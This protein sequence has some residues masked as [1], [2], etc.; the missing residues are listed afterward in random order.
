MFH[1][2]GRDAASWAYGP[3]TAATRRVD[4]SQTDAEGSVSAKGWWEVALPAKGTRPRIT[5]EVL[6][7]QAFDAYRAA[8][9]AIGNPMFGD[10]EI[11]R[12]R[13]QVSDIGL[14]SGSE[15]AL[16]VEE[17]AGAPPSEQADDCCE[18]T[19]EV[20]RW[21]TPYEQAVIAMLI[22]SVTA[23]FHGVK[24]RVGRPSELEPDAVIEFT[25]SVDCADSDGSP[26][27]NLGCN[28]MLRNPDLLR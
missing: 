23:W 11:R 15:G 10:V 13:E 19:V 25:L 12:V 28:E 8:A 21:Q 27:F 2:D 20:D 18:M 7:E 5:T 3:T 24:G 26:V 9:P 17:V 1:G 6:A 14:T 16:P 22:K 4:R